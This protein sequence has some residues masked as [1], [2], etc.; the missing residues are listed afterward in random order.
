[1]VIVICI[2]VL[3]VRKKSPLEQ[4]SAR[5]DAYR[6]LKRRYFNGIVIEEEPYTGSPVV[7]GSPSSNSDRA[8]GSPVVKS[9]PVVSTSRKVVPTVPGI[10][11]KHGNSRSHTHPHSITKLDKALPEIVIDIPQMGEGTTVGGNVNRFSVQNDREEFAWSAGLAERVTG[12][13]RGEEI[14]RLALKEIFETEFPRIRPNW[15]RNPE[16]K[17]KLE[18]DC[19]GCILDKFKARRCLAVEYSGKQHFHFP[20]AFHKTQKEFENQ[21]RRDI[22]KRETL[23]ALSINYFVVPYTVKYQHIGIFVLD[24]VR[25]LGLL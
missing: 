4:L 17:R 10:H 18:I 2:I 25:V 7:R 21:V 16:T 22:F 3:L 12:T 20:N 24:T 19:F 9:V 6:K 8:L 23:E 13:G 11:G 5:R 15:L 14:T 1:M